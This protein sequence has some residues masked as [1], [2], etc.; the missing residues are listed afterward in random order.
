MCGAYLS[1]A[2]CDALIAGVDL[3][4][5][6][7]IFGPT[8]VIVGLLLLLPSCAVSVR[9]LHDIGKSGWWSWLSLT[10]VGLAVLLFWT[11]RP[12]DRTDNQYGELV[13]QAG[14]AN[15]IR[16]LWLLAIA[17]VVIPLVLMMMA[18]VAL[19]GM[20]WLGYSPATEVVEGAE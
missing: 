5:Y 12:G 19:I 14:Q 13:E 6:T 9:R 20:T 16:K 11:V 10:I 7:D 15:P 3:E 17:A 1:A 2:Y 4:N 8:L 18:G